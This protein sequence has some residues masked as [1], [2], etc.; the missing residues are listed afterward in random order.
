LATTA[1]I[2]IFAAIRARL[3]PEFPARAPTR[4]WPRQAASRWHRRSPRLASIPALHSRRTVATVLAAASCPRAA[5]A[6]SGSAPMI[7]QTPATPTGST[8]R[9]AVLR[10]RRCPPAKIAVT[11]AKFVSA[12]S[13][14]ALLAPRRMNLRVAAA[15]RRVD[16]A[17]LVLRVDIAS[18]VAVSSCRPDTAQ[19]TV[20]RQQPRWQ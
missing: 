2:G 4:R 18:R 15:P 10:A 1:A 13:A 12:V 19:K 3:A 9:S 7:R 6:S 5:V 17:P 11:F 16:R 20:I 14:R 8:I